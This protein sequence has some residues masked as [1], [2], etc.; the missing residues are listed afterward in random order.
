MAQIAQALTPLPRHACRSITFDRG[1][2][3]IDWPHLQAEVGAQNWFC[4]AQSPWQKGAVEN[5]NKRLRRWLC[6]DTDPN[7]LSQEELRQLCAASMPRRASASASERLPRCSRLTYSDAATDGRNSPG[8]HCRIWASAST[9]LSRVCYSA[10]S[11]WRR[12]PF[13]SAGTYRR[14][15]ARSATPT[16]WQLELRAPARDPCRP[17]ALRIH[18]HD[19]DIRARQIHS[20]PDPLNAGTKHLNFAA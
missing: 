18:L 1:S 4:E 9:A 17:H 8:N 13:S 12:S 6:R 15:I 11:E 3:F 20:M 2:E 19:L 10:R 5:A 7:T 14:S 16:L